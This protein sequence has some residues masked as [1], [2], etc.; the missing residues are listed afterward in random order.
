MLSEYHEA[1]LRTHHRVLDW[2]DSGTVGKDD[3]EAIAANFAKLRGEQPGSP[4][5]EDLLEKF[6]WIWTTF[7]E[8]ANASKD[9][10]V[11]PEEFVASLSAAIDAGVRSDDRLLPMLFE[12]IDDDGDGVI[13]RRRAPAVL[14]G[15]RDRRRPVA[16]RLRAPRHRRRRLV[17]REE[18]LEA[19]AKFFFYDEEDAPGNTFWGPVHA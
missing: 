13:S 4:V 14:R 9:G 19:G 5:H 16:G 1:K 17:S 6:R 18:F 10:N 7:W 12:M 11:T 2:D 8:P 15:V 3:F